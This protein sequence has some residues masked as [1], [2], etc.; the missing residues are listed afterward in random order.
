VTGAAASPGQVLLAGADLVVELIPHCDSVPRDG[1]TDSHDI[2]PLSALGHR[3]AAALVTA[4]GPD[5]QAIFTSPALRCRQTVAPTAAATGLSPTELPALAESFDFA[6][7]AAWVSAI[8][9]PIAGPVSGAWSAG[10]MLSALGSMMAGYQGGRVVASSH[11]DVVPVLV[12]T[13]CA[14]YSVPVPELVNRGGW[15]SLRFRA[16]GFTVATHRPPPLQS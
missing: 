7:P 13:L 8:F 12:A 1:W 15:Y 6:E 11:G 9:A 4:L 3:Q 2:R 10:R 14:A 5:I 16:G